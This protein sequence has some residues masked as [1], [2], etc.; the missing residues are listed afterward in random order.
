MQKI[1]SVCKFIIFKE[2]WLTYI[3]V[4]ENKQKKVF[5]VQN[6]MELNFLIYGNDS[7][8]KS[9]EIKYLRINKL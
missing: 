4:N 7:D 6:M 2:N 9:N 5:K 1:P 8:K 3:K